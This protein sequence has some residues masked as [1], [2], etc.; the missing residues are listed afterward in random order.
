MVQVL[1]AGALVKYHPRAAKQLQAP[2]SRAGLLAARQ[3][4]EA[5][6]LMLPE[7]KQAPHLAQETPAPLPAEQ[8]AALRVKELEQAYPS[9]A[10]AHRSH[11]ANCPRR[12]LFPRQPAAAHRCVQ[13]VSERPGPQNVLTNRCFPEP[14]QPPAQFLQ[15]LLAL[16]LLAANRLEGPT[17]KTSEESDQTMQHPAPKPLQALAPL[18]PPAEQAKPLQDPPKHRPRRRDRPARAAPKE[19][20]HSPP[21]PP[22]RKSEVAVPH[23]SWRE[24]LGRPKLL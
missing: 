1:V 12:P 8:V 11:Q 20:P 10:G 14:V 7:P 18:A 2:K 3:L 9:L 15:E 16:E 4:E 6:S 21:P 13:E 24:A 19:P 23:L 22:A 17:A 5:W